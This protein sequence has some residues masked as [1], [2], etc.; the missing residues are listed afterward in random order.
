[1]DT[2]PNSW[3]VRRKRHSA[4]P[5]RAERG[6]FDVAAVIAGEAVG[7]I[8]DAPPAAEIVDRITREAEG[9]LSRGRSNE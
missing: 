6:D 1:M 5:R 7:L 9:L 2:K 8:H 3:S 4:T